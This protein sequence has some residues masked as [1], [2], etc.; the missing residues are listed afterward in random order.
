MLIENQTIQLKT[1]GMHKKNKDHLLSKGYNINL[2][3]IEVRI[4]DLLPTSTYMVNLIC[5][6]CNKNIIN[7]AYSKALQEKHCCKK[8]SPIKQEEIFLEKYGVRNPYQLDKVK[9]TFI[10]K[11]GVENPGQIP[12]VRKRV[13]NTLLERYGVTNS[14]QIES[15]RQTTLDNHGVEYP[16]QSEIVREKQK[17]TMIEE[18]GVENPTQN[19]EIYNGILERNIERWGVENPMQVEEFQKK[20][21]ENMLKTMYENG[22]M[23][24][25]RQQKHLHDLLGGELNYP[26]DRCSL[27]I[28]FP[29]EMIY[30]EYNGGGHYAW[31]KHNGVTD[32]E[33]HKKEMNRYGYLKTKNWRLIRII[34]KKDKLYEDKKIIKLISECK[35]YLNKGHSW[36]EIDMDKNVITGDKYSRELI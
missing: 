17:E 22:T 25:S 9:Q 18:Y 8:C 6:Y 3:Y 7:W 13:E 12:E 4:D 20:A 21:T 34:C 30:I 16:F 28:A 5:D 10:N 2:D 23:Q 32:E 15:V 1:K 14:Y 36:I 24:T 31:P 11:Y 19:E 35:D 33:L 27:D 26:I 29:K